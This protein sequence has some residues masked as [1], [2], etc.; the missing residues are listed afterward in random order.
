MILAFVW[1]TVHPTVKTNDC[2]TVY[3]YSCRPECLDDEEQTTDSCIS[4]ICCKPKGYI[5]ECNSATD[6]RKVDCEDKYVTDSSGKLGKCEYPSEISCDDSFD[7]DGDGLKDFSDSDCTETCLQK[8]GEIC[9]G[10]DVCSEN[11]IKAYDTAECC[12]G[13]CESKKTCSEQNGFECSASQ[14]CDAYLTASDT[15]YCC[16]S[17]CRSKSSI[18]PFIIIFVILILSGAAFFLYKK[19]FFRKKFEVKKPIFPA[20]AQTQQIQYRP[21]VKPLLA[22]QPIQPQQMQPLERRAAIRHEV[23][24]ELDETMRKLKKI[25]EEKK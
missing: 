23:K 6:C 10:N 13:A 18:I 15:L 8:G 12:V 4:G 2:E 9:S 22:Q 21:P 20:S 1:P 11:A 17:K 25:T 24:S 7:N 5:P 3:P 19:G 14:E 16:S